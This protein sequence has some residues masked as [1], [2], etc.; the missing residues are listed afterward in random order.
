MRPYKT[1]A[2]YGTG[3]FLN[4]QKRECPIKIELTPYGCDDIHVRWCVNGTEYHFFPESIVCGLFSDFMHAVYNLYHEKDDQH[5]FPNYRN[6]RLHVSNQDLAPCKDELQITTGLWWD[7]VGFSR[8]V[9]TRKNRSGHES[10]LVSSP[11]PISVSIHRSKERQSDTFTVDGKDLAYAIGKAATEAIKK[12]GFYGYFFS[13]GSDL[14]CGDYFNIHELLFF[15]AYALDAMEVRHL[16]TVWE[17]E[18]RW[19]H[20]ETTPFEKELELL[21][22]DM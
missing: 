21:L 14:E 20:A 16:E 2:R 18:D 6:K 19:H 7:Q 5:R 8:I 9:F 4:L 22:F 13:S 17:D 3:D 10:F 15:K 11:D 12:F 1:R